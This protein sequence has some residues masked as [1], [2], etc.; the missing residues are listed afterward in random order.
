MLNHQRRACVLGAMAMVLLGAS[1]CSGA[2]PPKNRLPFTTPDTIVAVRIRNVD[3]FVKNAGAALSAIDEGGGPMAEAMLGGM[4]GQLP[5][6]DRAGPAAILV[7]DPR[8]HR[9]PGVGVVT[10][11]DPALFRNVP[12][13]RTAVVG[14]LGV[15]AQ[16]AGALNE[17]VQALREGRV[18]AIPTRDMSEM[19]AVGAD[20]G[21]LLQRFKLEIGTGIQLAKL[22]LGGGKEGEFPLDPA[23]RLTLKALDYAAKLVAATEKQAGPA[24]LALS[25]NGKQVTGHLAL[26]AT[27]NTPFAAFLR[28][29]TVRPNAKLANY[30]PKDA[31]VTAVVASEP[32]SRD[33]LALGLLEIICD[34]AD[35]D[36]QSARSLSGAVKDFYGN[37]SGLHVS[38]ARATQ[39]EMQGIELHGIRDA[40]ACRTGV[41]KF[42]R[43]PALVKIMS[44]FGI[45][46]TL[47][48]AHRTYNRVPVDK[49]EMKINWQTLMGALPFPPEI[50]EAAVAAIKQAQTK[51]RHVMEMVYGTSLFAVV[52]SS[53]GTATMDKQI[54]LIRSRVPDGIGTVPEVA[55]AYSRQP[56]NVSALWHLSLF[57]MSDA[58]HKQTAKQL[59]VLGKEG[60]NMMPPRNDLPAKETPLSGSVRVEGNRVLVGVHVP[61]A[62]LSAFAQAM[63]KRFQ[64]EMMKQFGGAA[65]PGEFRGVV[66]PKRVE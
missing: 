37:L 60:P 14:K 51:D 10:L 66:A 55:A 9:I 56:R 15:I 46:M 17:V 22:T 53:T 48:E 5:G 54:D 58:I 45:T 11:K 40:A 4:I 23:K 21:G 20:V 47:T 52:D 30:I 24:E 59:A 6:I 29:Q 65:A 3:E 1:V 31:F 62:T 39:G 33:A 26:E 36:E 57:G 7:L 28:K 18:K 64:A 19:V 32:V 61:M 38:A 27:P 63:K 50:R 34:I 16:K 2:E 43:N 42:Y 12:I 8:K 35:V 49:L 41:R 25:F 13:G 44:R